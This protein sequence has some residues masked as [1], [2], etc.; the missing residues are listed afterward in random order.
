MPGVETIEADADRIGLALNNLIGNAI[1]HTSEGGVVEVGVAANRSGLRF[2]VKDSGEGVPPEFQKKVFDKFF[3]VPGSKSGGA[4]LGLS[5]A[6][7]IIEAHGGEMGVESRPGEGSTFW[8]SL[9][10]TRARVQSS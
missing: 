1:R 10:T 7:E 8:F 9:P 6:R 4:G 5:I 3:R 2:E